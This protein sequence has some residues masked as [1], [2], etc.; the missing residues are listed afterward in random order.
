M[1]TLSVLACLTL[2]PLLGAPTL[3][4]QETSISIHLV[5]DRVEPK[6]TPDG[7]SR[8]LTV[9]DP[10]W[11]EVET[12]G[13]SGHYL[14]PQ[15]VAE[16]FA[17]H[18]ELAVLGSERVE[19]RFR[20]QLALFRPGSV[21]LPPAQARVINDR[22]DT[23]YVPVTA[24]TIH[25]ESVLAPGD[26]L[27]ADI[28]P[29]WVTPGIPWWFWALLIALLLAVA[30]WWWLRNRGRD[31]PEAWVPQ[32]DAYER[33]KRRLEAARREPAAPL[34]RI[35]AATEIGEALRDYL[36]DGW[37]LASRERTTFELVP[38]LPDEIDS[39]RAPVAAVFSTVDLAKYARVAPEAGEVSRLAG[40]GLDLLER[41]E[42]TRTAPD[43][44]EL[45]DEAPEE[46]A[47]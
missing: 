15:S 24:D 14:L 1:R 28:K 44:S 5:P 19:G 32:P 23:L 31:E 42:T 21:L 16:A 4:A 43:E 11:V 47:S 35:A 22:G 25:V 26:T 30:L 2:A 3:S 29:L 18:P 45:I 8:G 40:R 7:E 37:G 13:P 12:R 41:L 27:L 33:A 6:I 17:P 36:A 38:I 39:E 9:G 10:F 46:V 34:P 20:L